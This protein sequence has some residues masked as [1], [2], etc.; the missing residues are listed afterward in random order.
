MAESAD[1]LPARGRPLT[2]RQVAALVGGRA[3]GGAVTVHGVMALAS[4][5]PDEAAYFGKGPGRQDSRASKRD[6]DTLQ[7]SQAGL[8]LLPGDVDAAGRPCVRVENPPLAAALLAQH[9]HPGPTRHAAGVH[10]QAMVEEGAQLGAEVSVGPGCVVRMG[11]RIGD[12]TTLSANVH[13]GEDAE[14]G[15]GCYL[16]PG[17]VI[18][19]G[20]RLGRGCTLHAN[21]VIGADGFGYVWDGRRHVKVPQIG[22]V[23]I[24]EGVEIGAGSCV[25]RA[26]FE[27][28]VIG[29]GSV[30]DNLV[31]VGH[32]CRIGRLNVLCAGVALGGHTVTGDG[33]IFGGAAVSGGHVEIG[34]GAIVIGRAEVVTDIEAGRTVAGGPAWD[35]RDE[36]RVIHQIRRQVK[37]RRERL[38]ES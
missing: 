33:V 18:Y 2:S 5:Q 16:H 35:L 31:Q 37:A 7:S 3:E 4:A 19:S 36:M 10:P 24:G 25:D 6:L 9:F 20:V 26:T 15:A 12:G 27:A 13:V 14:I 8:L 30:L 11:A 17:V 38:Q 34:D 22:T 29:D 23:E 28:T 32:N 1:A 21:A